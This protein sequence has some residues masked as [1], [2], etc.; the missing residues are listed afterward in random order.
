[1]RMGRFAGIRASS[2][3]GFAAR[4]LSIREPRRRRGLLSARVSE[5]REGG[6]NEQVVEGG[7]LQLVEL[8]LR[9]LEV[10]PGGGGEEGG[11]VAPELGGAVF[12]DDVDVF[13][14]FGLDQPVGVVGEDED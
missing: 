6:E 9:D 12:V 13:A 1:M 3:W 14:A 7:G 2:Q 5:E 8:D 4:L 11:V 10:A